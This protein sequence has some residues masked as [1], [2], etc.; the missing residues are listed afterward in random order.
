MRLPPLLSF[1]PQSAATLPMEPAPIIR[2]VTRPAPSAESAMAFLPI[3]GGTNS[4]ST[5]LAQPG[6]HR[7]ARAVSCSDDRRFACEAHTSAS[8]HTSTSGKP[9][10]ARVLEEIAG[11][12]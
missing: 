3:S 2:H 6:S 8:S 9:P 5:R 11:L 7:P 12:E 4:G 10:G 1:A